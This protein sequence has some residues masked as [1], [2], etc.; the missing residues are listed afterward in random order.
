MGPEVSCSPF[1]FVPLQARLNNSNK[2]LGP[3]LEEFGGVAG[4]RAEVGDVSKEEPELGVSFGLGT[5]L[6]GRAVAINLRAF[7]AWSVRAVVWGETMVGV[8]WL[9]GSGVAL[10]GRRAGRLGSWSFITLRHAL[11]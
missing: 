9:A 3:V 11:V 7:T 6:C 5:T 10:G 8:V 2:V 1:S 4:W